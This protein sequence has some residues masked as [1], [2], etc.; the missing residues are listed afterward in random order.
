M[1]KSAA[2]EANEALAYLKAGPFSGTGPVSIAPQYIESRTKGVYTRMRTDEATALRK[3]WLTIVRHIGS[4]VITHT[5][6]RTGVLSN[7][8]LQEF[9]D[10]SFHAEGD[11]HVVSVAKHKTVSTACAQVVL[12]R[13][14]YDI[15][16]EYYQLRLRVSNTDYDAFLINTEG[17]PYKN[18]LK[19]F[20]AALKGKNLPEL[21]S[22]SIRIFVS[23]AAK[24]QPDSARLAEAI[25]H[26]ESTAKRHYRPS[27]TMDAVRN[28]S[29]MTSLR[30][31]LS[32][33]DLSKVKKDI[34]DLFE[35]EFT[36]L[37]DN[38]VKRILSE[39]F[40]REVFPSRRNTDTIVELAHQ[41][42]L[43]RRAS[44]LGKLCAHRGY[45]DYPFINRTV[46]KYNWDYSKDYVT[47]F[48]IE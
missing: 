35:D 5:A 20:N 30:T 29:K 3:W 1:A 26:S 31:G 37:S 43:H 22:R 6:H 18:F 14:V 8:T 47:N 48:I 27:T 38:E 32:D 24:L 28:Y 19:D 45:L 42:L 2:D 36:N 13:D 10:A 33:E 44:I 17:K 12:E 9:D 39:Y 16:N 34:H 23:S 41:R 11:L 21:S 25:C 4:I 40:G 15:C 46:K 7:M